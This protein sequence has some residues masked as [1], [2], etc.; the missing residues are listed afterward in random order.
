M[1]KINELKKQLEQIQSKGYLLKEY[2]FNNYDIT[3]ILE[4]NIKK[5]R[6]EIFTKENK[7]LLKT[8]REENFNI[9][10]EEERPIKEQYPNLTEEE[11]KQATKKTTYTKETLKDFSEI[12]KEIK[13]YFSKKTNTDLKKELIKELWLNWEGCNWELEK[14]SFEEIKQTLETQ[15]LKELVFN[16]YFGE[17]GVKR[18]VTERLKKINTLFNIILNKKVVLDFESLDYCAS[19]NEI[20]EATNNQQTGFKI[21]L[22]LNRKLKIKFTDKKEQAKIRSLFLKDKFDSFQ[23]EFYVLSDSFTNKEYKEM[24]RDLIVYENGINFFTNL[25]LNCEELTNFQKEKPKIK[26]FKYEDLDTEEKRFSC[27]FHAQK[28]DEWKK[29]R[30]EGVKETTLDNYTKEKTFKLLRGY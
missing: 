13:N 16:N 11:I 9:Y 4:N 20:Q 3:S 6:S 28:S 14:K 15:H 18:D 5:H 22:F 24:K 10:R 17:Y 1:K 8:D 25:K 27:V 21:K 19:L 26:I 23:K 7:L 29:G 2:S 12:E 30:I